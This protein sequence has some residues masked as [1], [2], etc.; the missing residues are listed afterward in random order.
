M[1]IFDDAGAG[2]AGEIS[3]PD[4]GRAAEQIARQVNQVLTTDLLVTK[5]E[6]SAPGIPIAIDDLLS[7]PSSLPPTGLSGN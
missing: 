5:F 6:L 2:D 4:N 3:A 7:S 1:P